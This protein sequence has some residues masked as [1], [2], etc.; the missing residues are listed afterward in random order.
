[1]STGGVF[2]CGITS[3]VSHFYVLFC[4]LPLVLRKSGDSALWAR[5]TVREKLN[6]SLLSGGAGLFSRFRPSTGGGAFDLPRV[7]VLSTVVLRCL[8]EVV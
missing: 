3:T 2:P 5:K 4:V 6:E 8:D 1:M 7:F